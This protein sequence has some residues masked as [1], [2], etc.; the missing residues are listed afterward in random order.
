[1]NGENATFKELPTALSAVQTA[2]RSVP[3]VA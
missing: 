1:L 2:E 3:R